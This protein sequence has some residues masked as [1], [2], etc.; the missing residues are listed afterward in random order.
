MTPSGDLK[1]AILSGSPSDS[2]SVDLCCAMLEQFGV[3][4][5]RRVLSAHRQGERVRQYVAD[6]ESRGCQVFICMAGMA[7]HLPGVVASLTARPVLGVPL[8]GGI[9]DG[10]DALLSVVQMPKGVPVASLAVGSA[11]ARNAALLAVQ[12]LALA[13]DRL[14]TAMATFRREMA[15]GGS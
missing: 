9:L 14:A 7:A 11:G 8:K 10:L 5:E 6:A 15:E 2:E 3:S 4:H 13:D 12:I 1:V